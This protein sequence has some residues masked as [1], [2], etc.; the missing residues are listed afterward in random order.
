M[1]DRTLGVAAHPHGHDRTAHSVPL[2]PYNMPLFSKHSNRS[3]HALDDN[4]AGVGSATATTS[5]TPT[6]PASTAVSAALGKTDE[7][8]ATTT[9]PSSQQQQ[10]DQQQQQ[11]Q[12][13]A[14]MQLQQQQ[15]Q[16]RRTS[17]PYTAS[18]VEA[19]SPTIDYPHPGTLVRPQ[20]TY[21]SPF[22]QLVPVADRRSVDD[23]A[24][25]TPRTQ[26]PSQA[27]NNG[28]TSGS[29]STKPSPT[30]QSPVVEHKKSKSLFDRMR[31][32]TRAPDPNNPSTPPQGYILSPGTAR[33][34]SRRLQSPPV[35][36]TPSTNSTASPDKAQHLDWQASQEPR[37]YLP[38][39]QE[40]AEDRAE[41]DPYLAQ[42]LEQPETRTSSQEQ[43]QQPT[44]RSVPSDLEQEPDDNTQLVVP[45]SSH[46]QG[47]G[48]DLQL[49]P[50]Q[51]ALGISHDPYSQNFETV[52]QLSFDTS[53]DPRDDFQAAELSNNNSPTSNANSL[54]SEHTN[55]R[56]A[57]ATR[58]PREG[59]QYIMAP[60]G[61]S[62][63]ARRTTDPKQAMQGNPAQ[64]DANYRQQFGGNSTPTAV[65]S[66]SPLPTG[67]GNDYR[68]GPPQREQFGDRGRSTPPPATERDVNDAYKEICEY[69]E[70][71]PSE[72]C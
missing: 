17:Q 70:K 29:S 42:N 60:G 69:R 37:S 63:Q 55:T 71:K 50:Y 23:L 27:P 1:D 67:P 31:S 10:P 13:F 57:P 5:T 53:A 44:I 7:A 47:Q 38:S 52:S 6:S 28:S 59:S 65:P 14:L 54:R 36:R 33:R 45:Q 41:L 25:T 58:G 62:Q 40:H 46:Q 43:S 11:Q 4:I 16:K 32:S 49:S 68:G 72:P 35:L 20:S 24:L 9:T 21:S 22:P 30:T 56:T 66:A 19:A 61:T 51:N 8:R 18:P 64:A 12:S 2:S 15:L 26:L 3:K 48:Q 39:P 34:L